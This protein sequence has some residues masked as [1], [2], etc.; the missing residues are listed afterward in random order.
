M[1]FHLKPRVQWDTTYEMQKAYKTYKCNDLEV[2][3]A[4]IKY[5]AEGKAISMQDI[6]L[7]E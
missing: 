3:G 4:L 7:L 1:V 6:R 2:S 5:L